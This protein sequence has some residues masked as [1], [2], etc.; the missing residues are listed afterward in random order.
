MTIA[1]GP[2]RIPAALIDDSAEAV[3]TGVF[4]D[5][6]A[7]GHGLPGWVRSDDFQRADFR[8]N[9]SGGRTK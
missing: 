7:S 6:S 1:D 2:D 5:R 4:V 9:H 3:G 8:Q